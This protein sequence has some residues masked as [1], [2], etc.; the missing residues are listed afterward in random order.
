[1]IP[2]EQED[3]ETMLA[4]ANPRTLED[5]LLRLATTNQRALPSMTKEPLHEP[6]LGSAYLG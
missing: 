5:Q 1:M 2:M 6:P 4:M 3:I